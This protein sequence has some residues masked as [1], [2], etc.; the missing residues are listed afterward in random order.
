MKHF[1]RALVSTIISGAALLAPLFLVAI[2]FAA[3]AQLLVKVGTPVAELFVAKGTFSHPALY[4]P[5]GLALLIVVSMFTGLCLHLSFMR[6]FAAWL[7]RRLLRRLPGFEVYQHITQAFT[8][9]SSE[10]S[11]KPALLLSE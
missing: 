7:R 1:L 9:Q 6:S 2:T 4:V 5:F 3:L 11:F 10:I 8:G